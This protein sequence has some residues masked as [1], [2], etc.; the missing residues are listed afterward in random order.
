MFL[1]MQ[2]KLCYIAGIPYIL[3]DFSRNGSCRDVATRLVSVLLYSGNILM[4]FRPLPQASAGRVTPQMQLAALRMFVHSHTS[5][6]RALLQRG[7]T[8]KIRIL[9][10]LRLPRVCEGVSHRRY[11][12]T[13]WGFNLAPAIDLERELSLITHHACIRSCEMH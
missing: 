2:S 11:P 1:S 5:R 4:S 3:I 8:R 13:C 12:R 10:V 9:L 6:S 7:E